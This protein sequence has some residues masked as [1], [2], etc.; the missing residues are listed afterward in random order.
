[1]N[2][3]T[4]LLLLVTLIFG[5]SWLHASS[6]L[7]KEALCEKNASA[8]AHEGKLDEG[9]AAIR[10]CIKDSPS[11]AKAHV[12]L[13]YLLLEKG[14]G[15]QATTSFDKA[16]ELR[17]HSSAAK[18]GKGIILAQAGDLK[19][20]ESLLKDALKLNPNPARTYYELGLI[21]EQLGDMQQ[22]ISHFKQG[23]TTRE[24]EKR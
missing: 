11:R 1:M 13:G 10:Q 20:A 21:Y 19:G 24:Q 4:L 12:V 15:Q 16:L 22:A 23:I 18:T 6:A 8:L 3:K 14:A 7:G 2:G 5:P 9:L 17:P